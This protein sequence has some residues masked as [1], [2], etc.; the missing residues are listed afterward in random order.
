MDVH[1]LRP[2]QQWAWQGPPLSDEQKAALKAEWAKAGTFPCANHEVFKAAE[3]AAC[4][5]VAAGA[6]LKEAA[7]I[8]AGRG[9]P[10]FPCDPAPSGPHAKAPMT[11]GGFYA[12]TVDET[13]VTWWWDERPDALIGY[14]TG[15]RTNVLVVDADV[16]GHGHAEDEDGI[17]AWRA[18]ERKND[19]VRTRTHKTAGGGLHLIFA[20]DEKRPVG[21]SKG[22]LPPGL[23]VRGDGGFVI[24][25]PS[26][27][28]DGREWRVDLDEHPADAPSWLLDKIL[29]EEKGE[30]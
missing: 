6:S 15:R 25:P 28:E 17:E 7:L 24:L 11:K 12:A 14:P 21:T 4:A 13:V 27:L 1:V 9:V 23:D 18:L 22:R 19:K 2:E 10:V 8:L 29:G 26:R 30:K 16:P 20:Y 5:T 3:T